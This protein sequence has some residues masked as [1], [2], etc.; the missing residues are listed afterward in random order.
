MPSLIEEERAARELKLHYWLV[1]LASSAVWL[2]VASF[3]AIPSADPG[4][5]VASF[6]GG[7]FGLAVLPLLAMRLGGRGVG[8]SVFALFAAGFLQAE[9]KLL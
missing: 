5:A 1:V 3:K 9:L 6:L 4:S 7:T 8:W 2:L